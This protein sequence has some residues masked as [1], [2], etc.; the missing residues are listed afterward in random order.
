MNGP[1]L[2]AQSAFYLTQQLQDWQLS[3]RRNDGNH[4]ML[5]V[6]QELDAGQ[7]RQLSLYLAGIPPRPAPSDR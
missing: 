1:P 7:I 6:A 3:K 4:V 2:N 5:K